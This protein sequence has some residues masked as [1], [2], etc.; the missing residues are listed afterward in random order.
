[1]AYETQCGGCTNFDFQ[2]DNTKGYCSW[3]RSYYYPGDSCSHQNPREINS[4]CYIT[5]IVCDVLGFADDCNVLDTL[6]SFR[7]NV[8]QKDSKYYNLLLEYDMIGPDIAYFIKKEYEKTNDIEMWVQ[9]YN[10]YLQPTVNYINN[11]EFDSAVNRYKGMVETLKDYFGLQDLH[12][13]I[14]NYDI[15]NGGHGQLK[16]TNSNI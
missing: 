7:N 5:T 11:G 1:M 8:L 13:N 15:S 12:Y 4:G 3:Y 6:R 2:G 14:F 16:L 10:F 9:F